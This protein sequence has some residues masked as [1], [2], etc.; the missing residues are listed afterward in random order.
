MPTTQQPKCCFVVD[1]GDL[2]DL[3]ILLRKLSQEHSYV[4]LHI[5]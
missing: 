2:V 1:H 3:L 5:Y 4:I